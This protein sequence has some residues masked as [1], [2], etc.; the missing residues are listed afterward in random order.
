VFPVV[1]PRIETAQGRKRFHLSALRIRMTNR[2]DLTRRIRK[3]LRMTTSARRVCS[4]TRQRRLRRVVFTTMTQQTRQSR[5]LRVVMFE[6]RIVT[7]LA[8]HGV[9]E[10]L[11]IFRDL[12]QPLFVARIAI[13]RERRQLALLVMTGETD[14]MTRE[15]GLK[16]FCLCLTSLVAVDTFR[17]GVLVMWKCNMKLGNKVASLCGCEKRFTQTRKRIARSV[18]WGCFYMAVGTDPRDRPLT[19]EEL[20]PVTIQTSRM[21]RKLSHIRKRRVPFTNFLP[22][23]GGKFMTGATRELLLVDVSGM[24][25]VCIINGRPLSWLRASLSFNRSG[26]DSSKY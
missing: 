15:P 19:R 1:K 12:L 6:L 22:V 4:F 3:L 9:R 21:F 24:R 2:A 7:R 20:L 5:M 23:F 10:E 13:R 25:E 26:Q 8:E 11:A 17:I 18:E 16:T 14:R